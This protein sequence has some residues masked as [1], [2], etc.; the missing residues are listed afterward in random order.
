MAAQFAVVAGGDNNTIADGAS[1]SVI[2]GGSDNSVGTLLGVVA[3]GYAN[4]V[5]AD[6]YG[7]VVAGGERNTA[8]A[9]YGAIGGGW[10]N[11]FDGVA[12]AIGGGWLNTARSEW[13]VI[14]GGSENSLNGMVG[15]VGGGWRNNVGAAFGVVAGGSTNG[16]LGFASVVGG[17]WRNVV[18]ASKY[19]VVGGGYSNS[20]AGLAATVAGGYSN[21]MG[22]LSSYGTV[23]GG[24]ANGVNGY[25]TV[26]SG[27]Q[28]NV[29]NSSWSVVGGGRNNTLL[30][31]GDSAVIGGGDGNTV[32][33][34]FAVIGG[35][36]SN[37]AT[38]RT[39]AIGGGAYNHNYG[40]VSTIAGGM[41]VSVY[42]AYGTVAGGHYQSL[43]KQYGTIGGGGYNYNYG[44]GGT[45][46]G[47]MY[48]SVYGSWGTVSG[49]YYQYVYNQYGTIGGGGY[50]YNYG[51][52]GTIAGGM[53]NVAN[54]YG[55]VGGGQSNS[56]YGPWGGIASGKNNYVYGFAGIVA[57]G[58]Y[59]YLYDAYTAIGG[60]TYNSVLDYGGVVA[61]GHGNENY[62]YTGAIAGGYTNYLG[63]NASYGAIGGGY[64]NSG[65]GYAVV[66]TGGYNNT[67]TG[68]HAVVGGG[69]E[70]A[71]HG[72]AGVVAGGY[73]NHNSAHGGTIAGG[74]ANY[75][76]TPSFT[77][78]GGG[79][80][81]T[82]R[83]YAT[84]IAGGQRN[85]ANSS[86]GVVGGGRNN[87][88]RLFSNSS[89]IAGGE[90][91]VVGASFA[92][93]CG[94]KDNAA[95]GNSCVVA[96][97][98]A[99]TA[100]GSYAAVG[101][102][103]GNYVR[104]DMGT[105]AGGEH[106]SVN[107]AWGSIGGG[108]NHD[109]VRPYGVIG[110]GGHNF[111]SGY[112]STIAGGMNNSA[113]GSWSTVA[114][115]YYVHVS[116]AWGAVSGGR[117]QFVYFP[118]GSIGGGS[119]NF[120]YG[121][122]GTIGGGM[123]N[124][125]WY[126]GS[127]GGGT[128]NSARG[129]AAVIPGGAGNYVNS[130]W[131]VIGGGRNN[132]LLL[133]SQSSVIAGG[134]ENLA[135]A[136]FAVVGG[137]QGNVA[138]GNWS[139]VSGGTRNSALGTSSLA[140]GAGAVASHDAA[141]VFSFSMTNA[142]CRS[143]GNSTI[144]LCADNGVFVNG[145]RVP[146]AADV[147]GIRTDLRHHGALI[148]ESSTNIDLLQAMTIALDANVSALHSG[149]ALLEERVASVAGDVVAI[150]G[151][152]SVH[153]AELAHVWGNLS[154]QT[155]SLLEVESLLEVHT[156]ELAQLNLS[157]SL[158]QRQVDEL[159]L[160]TSSNTV[161]LKQVA[162]NTTATW[163][164]LA[165]LLSRVIDN[166]NAM[167]IVN[168]TA[169]TT[170][171]DV[172]NLERVSALLARNMTHLFDEVGTAHARIA[173]L[174]VNDTSSKVLAL[175]H[176]VSILE[177]NTTAV[178]ADVLDLGNAI[179][180]VNQSLVDLESIDI[181]VLQSNVTTLLQSHSAVTEHTAGIEELQASVAML[182]NTVT[183]Q[184]SLLASNDA[185]IAGLEST[186]ATQQLEITA[187]RSTVDS[188]NVSADKQ[189][190]GISE[191]EVSLALLNQTV[192]LQSNLLLTK[193]AAIASLESEASAQKLEISELKGT[194]NTMN[195]SL[196]SLTVAV[197]QMVRATSFAAATFNTVAETAATTA[198]SVVTTDCV[199]NHGPCDATTPQAP[200]ALS[201]TTSAP[202]L[203]ELGATT[204][205]SY[206][207][208]TSETPIKTGTVGAAATH[209]T[210]TTTTLPLPVV[211][212]Q[213]CSTYTCEDVTDVFA[214]NSAVA[215]VA[216]VDS[217]DT[218]TVSLFH[219]TLSTHGGDVVWQATSDTRFAS[220]VPSDLD[221]SSVQWYRLHVAVDLK[222]GRS[223]EAISESVQFAA[224][225]TLYGVAVQLVNS[226]AAANWF[227]VHVNATDATGLTFEYWI[228]DTEGVW[229]Y[230]VG[231]SDSSVATVVVPSTK[232]VTL[233]VT[234]TNSFESAQSCTD[235][236]MLPAS[237]SLN[238]S[239]EEVLQ[240]ALQLVESGA[241][242]SGV[243]LSA[244]DVVEDDD[245]VEVLLEAFSAAMQANGTALSQDVVVLNALVDS[246]ATASG[247][248]ELVQDVGSRLTADAGS[249]SLELY[250]DT[251]GDYGT[252]LVT[253][254][255][256]LD[257]V[258]D[259]DEY[260]GTV[261]SANAAGSVPDGEVSV[262]A[263]D[264]YSLS[265]ASSENVVAVDAGAATVM[266]AVD[267][268]ST[269]AVST[270][271]GTA[272]MTNTSLLATIH[273]V[274]VEGGR[275]AG[276]A[277]DVHSAM[278]LKLS[279]SGETHAIRK[280]ASCVYY[281]EGDGSWSERGVVLRGMELDDAAGARVVCSSSHLT[282][283][284]VGDSSEVARVVESKIAS[285]ADR[286][287]KMNNVNFLDDGTAINWN[288]LG[289]FL[290]AT[291][292][293]VI[294]IVVAKVKGRKAAVERGR[295]TFQQNGQ[296]SKPNT[297]GS[298]EYEAVLRRWVSGADSAKLVVVE[299]LTSNAML[300]L[301]FHWEHE[302]VV[303]GR[304]DK[305]VI[306]FGAVLMTFVSSAFLFDPLE[307][308]DGDLLVA[309]WSALVTAVLSNILLL[310]VQHF[311]PYMVSNVNSL[312]TMTRMP[313]TLLKREMKRRSCW[314]PARRRR[315]TV[316]V[317]ARVLI[318]W[319][320]LMGDDRGTPSK[321][322]EAPSAEGTV[323]H[324]S[325]QL[326]FLHCSV[327]MPSATA[328]NVLS[329]VHDVARVSADR[330]SAGV[331]LLQRQ[332][333]WRS[334]VKRE[335][336]NVEFDAWYVGLRRKRHVLA[337]LSA[338]VLLTLAV[339]TLAICLLL[340]GTFNDG[341]SLRWATD[342]AQSLV[343]QIFVTDPT[344][345]LLVIF[346]KLF[347]SWAFLRTG[348]QRL[349]RQLRGKEEAVEQQLA[350][351]SA[352]VQVVK[353]RAR[354]LQ[355]VA[356]ASRAVVAR[357]KAEKKT[358]KKRCKVVLKDIALA[359]A[360]ISRQRQVI[361]RPKRIQVETWD[362]EESALNA[363]EATT[364]QSLK[365]IEA[366]LTVL[367]GDQDSAVDQL[368]VAQETMARLQK[369]LSS[370]AKAKMALRNEMAKVEDKAAPVPKRAAVVP[371]DT[372]VRSSISVTA[373]GSQIE[374]PRLER[375]SIPSIQSAA[376]PAQSGMDTLRDVVQADNS[377][378]HSTRRTSHRTSRRVNRV[379]QLRQRQQRTAWSGQ[380][381]D[382]A[383]RRDGA[384]RATETTTPAP[385]RGPM[386]WAEIREFQDSLKV[387][388][389]K[390]AAKRSLARRPPRKAG[391][392]GNLSPQA[393]RVMLERRER[394]RQML[395]Q[396]RRVQ[397]PQTGQHATE[398]WQL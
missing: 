336:R 187:L 166:Q 116:G 142:S 137:G 377:P 36:N 334:R 170:Q 100:N 282:L 357:E 8:N 298:K 119:Y 40:D 237:S 96:G 122:A 368:R 393:V 28:S 227:Q 10:L 183:S 56:A 354:A 303:F 139:V 105:V 379:R 247:V 178:A 350:T 299:L 376:K 34:R 136:A 238:V 215:V 207:T 2:G 4:S 180:R 144:A 46:G 44:Y 195:A 341:E 270:W 163:L 241:A 123:E 306:L 129:Y 189:S 53:S 327:K 17:G 212:V 358:A 323:A 54:Q 229:Q 196:A 22:A 67:A 47:G 304:A 165:A 211:T 261:C 390:A 32:G 300:G 373:A 43:Y 147:A 143:L 331:V 201:N 88:L 167:E 290:G 274:H 76:G 199:T 51:Y 321:S 365:S 240:D 111:N 245:D 398:T 153:A 339:F 152:V 371:V 267:G 383:A 210:T 224:P 63:A 272:N 31:D 269:V 29:A 161:A 332:L 110:G 219:F 301:L 218:V 283:F 320:R 171:L 374:E 50:N 264:S 386:T 345:T 223:T 11:Y 233:Q 236:P 235:C 335:A 309:L 208:S 45:I 84:V 395:E 342:V 58:T 340:S 24:L 294:V 127:V 87:T 169:M 231:N 176:D 69:K 132:T 157:V 160:T 95:T 151:D 273:G 21:S 254:D 52:A 82:A 65:H 80:T 130:S 108:R 16:N 256:A 385:R 206:A 159:D 292:L 366:A 355:V 49:G 278:T 128:E 113:T 26:I 356:T 312:T 158:Q 277:V 381:G 389:A 281:D 192:A 109:V 378:A 225:P 248:L 126:F 311:L 220:F 364:R 317:Q 102:G 234:V 367:E 315:N 370:I 284:T 13:G 7:S 352:N 120:N 9:A 305:A 104:G 343:V 344:I 276:D 74:V 349:K 250:L 328:G 92:T 55:A 112:A 221:V 19:A 125:V 242:G 316:E 392:L 372:H 347:V 197:E 172:S 326:H 249:E 181:A 391:T 85:L 39:S 97:G 140:Q 363:R 286:V 146:T 78:V 280:A 253:Q 33:A 295:L 382:D 325:T 314:K 324:V 35:G 42:S 60:G 133:D 134:Q 308:A 226:S 6:G 57:G 30:L 346:G 48:V 333:R 397:R 266:A 41:Y 138:T 27:G 251:V 81:N 101:G 64:R 375:V 263:E 259:M 228:V 200:G 135:E 296:L 68:D 260:L 230:R 177:S 188:M 330:V 203:N 62:G 258:A 302:A 289:V 217:V 279:L 23:G 114:G 14:A 141:A 117:N 338:S 318:H 148:N 118:F 149:A 244:L 174:D 232:N 204:M 38:G 124:V 243:L 213:G 190:L 194:V 252:A 222:D 394:R 121:Y 70:N 73:A 93:L 77:S 86:W 380:G 313:T 265:C 319:L 83:G 293:F 173:A 131:G 288:I 337:M 75:L 297:M 384:G 214:W 369:K 179:R 185:V 396:R 307:S 209:V 287:D 175:N 275:T 257:G 20:N 388:A 155:G 198:E 91:N 103:S 115:G 3:G 360:T 216:T 90:R 25:G 12:G 156:S 5:T 271:N 59:N 15:V 191:L 61:G 1:V 66:I 255:D 193:D 162:A 72:Y 164:E 362:T 106:V 182:N 387:K 353:E 99:N 329:K 322:L 71:A 94:G 154:H 291:V 239:I 310:P 150:D 184:S 262:Y 246:A 361:P 98:H 37:T 18:A 205:A 168:T 186:T 268:V 359:K 145:Q 79:T 202:G 89:V 351:V 285:F 107:G 348:K